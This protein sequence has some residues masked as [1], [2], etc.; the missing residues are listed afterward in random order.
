MSDE[1]RSRFMRLIS[2]KGILEKKGKLVQLRYGKIDDNGYAE[3]EDFTTEDLASVDP[4]LPVIL[5]RMFNNVR[6]PAV[7][8][9]TIFTGW[10]IN[11]FKHWDN[12]QALCDSDGEKYHVLEVTR[13]IRF[14]QN[15]EYVRI[16][17]TCYNVEHVSGIPYVTHTKVEQISVHVDELEKNF[18][19]WQQRYGMMQAL[20]VDM[21]ELVATVFPRDA[22]VKPGQV[23]MQGV[24]FD[25]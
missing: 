2:K 16:R 4:R 18:P 3:H 25:H 5:D 10:L 22:E 14:E 20:G 21:D 7:P 1:P 6:T 17:A 9:L 24:E 15:P 13:F 23:T 11:T 8:I 19:G 12:P